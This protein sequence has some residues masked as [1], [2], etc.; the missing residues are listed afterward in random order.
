MR[1]R[2]PRWLRRHVK[3]VAAPGRR[4]WSVTSRTGAPAIAISLLRRPAP[5]RVTIEETP[6]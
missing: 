6:R 2:S 5:A 4:A 1:L 3:V